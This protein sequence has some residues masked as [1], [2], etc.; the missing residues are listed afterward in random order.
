MQIYQKKLSDITP[1]NRNPRKKYDILKVAKSIEQFG[2]QQPIVVDRS[3]TIIVGHGRFEA[4]K[5]LKLET[6]P[7]LIADLPPEKAK[8][9]RIAD[10]KTNEYSDW[11]FPLLNKEFGDLLDI[12]FDLE[13][14]GFDNEELEKIITTH[15][16]NEDVEFPSI[17]NIENRE[18]T[19]MTFTLHNDQADFIKDVIKNYKS[20]NNIDHEQ[21]TNSNGNAIYYICLEIDKVLKLNEKLNEQTRQE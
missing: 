1:Y 14:T 5:H 3:G 20:S 12:N 4:S 17:E 15:K 18:W 21:N 8:A 11:D 2:F 6:V 7:V 13:L 9:Y 19:D 16:N 10:N